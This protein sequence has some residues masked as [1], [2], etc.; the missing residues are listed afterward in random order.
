[1]CLA[2]GFLDNLISYRWR[3]RVSS[4]CWSWHCWLT[5]EAGCVP[6]SAPLPSRTLWQPLSSPV[7]LLYS[8]TTQKGK[9]MYIFLAVKLVQEIS[10]LNTVSLH[11][12]VQGQFDDAAK[13]DWW[14][15]SVTPALA[16]RWGHFS[17]AFSASHIWSFPF[18]VSQFRE[19]TCQEITPFPKAK[20]FC[21]HSPWNRWPWDH[22]RHS[23]SRSEEGI[24]ESKAA[25]FGI[26]Q[27]APQ[28]VLI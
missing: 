24:T 18:V 8:S 4:C 21:P 25:P 14:D 3:K 5:P 20:L 19:L 2:R 7:H 13:A 17:P 22:T 11:S 26:R 6:H 9:A 10:A 1:M 23:A 28:V 27:V 12:P 15:G 16:T